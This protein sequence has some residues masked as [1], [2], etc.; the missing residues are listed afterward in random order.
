MPSIS[1]D[2]AARRGRPGATRSTTWATTSCGSSTPSSGDRRSSAACRRA[3]CF[4]M[5]VGVRKPGQ[6]LAAMYEDP[7][8]FASE[9]KPAYG[10]ESQVIGP[11]FAMWTNGSGTSGASATGRAARRCAPRPPLLLPWMANLMTPKPEEPPQQFLKEYDPEW[12]RCLLDRHRGGRRATTSACSPQRQGAGA[13]HP[14]PPQ[15]RAPT[16]ATS[17]AALADKQAEAGPTARRAR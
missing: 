11:I 17:S 14:P 9:R 12:G 4:R 16:R 3:A 2:R 13:A 15:H 7:P 5:A 8:L 10:P 6:V 1:A